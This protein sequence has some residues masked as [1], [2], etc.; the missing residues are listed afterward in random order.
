MQREVWFSHRENIY[1]VENSEFRWTDKK[2]IW[3][4]DHCTV[5]LARSYKDNTLI[6]V[7]R[8]SSNTNS[9][10]MGDMPVNV[11]YM[12]GFAIK[13]VSELKIEKAGEW[14]GPEDRLIFQAGSNYWIWDWAKEGTNI[15][16]SPVYELHESISKELATQLIASDN[17]FKVDLETE[18]GIVPVIYQPAVDSLKNFIREIH[19][20][21]L[22]EESN[23]GS[24]IIEVTLIFNNEEL[25]RH[26]YKG[27][28]NK[29]YERIRKE[30]NGRTVDVESF[31]MV[32]RQD[33]N[34][35]SVIE[36]VSLLFEGIYSDYPNKPHSIEDDD[37]H[38]DKKDAKPHSVIYYFQDR[39]HPVIFI[40]TSNHAMAADDNNRHLWKWEYI[41]WVKNKPVIFDNK[42]RKDI[43]EKFKTFLGRIVSYFQAS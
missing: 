37:I 40:N 13:N 35:P 27:F 28:L 17:I 36:D 20:A 7:V 42:S 10:Y 5:S 25:R 43:D 31:R 23:D 34:D 15:N 22:P 41:P 33:K 24:Y 11:R 12:L 16:E 21:R 6:G 8:S 26:S 2:K 19:C 30:L 4:W 9:K 14:Q 39:R 3:N 1:E 32:V 38:G 18:P 29:I